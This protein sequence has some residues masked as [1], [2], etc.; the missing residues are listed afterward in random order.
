MPDEHGPDVPIGEID[1]SGAVPDGFDLTAFPDAP[2]APAGPGGGGD[3]PTFTAEASCSTQCIESGVAYPRGFGAQL[4]VETT[5]EARLWMAVV[6]DLESDGGEDGLTYANSTISN[7]RVTEFSWALDHLEPG[8]TYYVTVT[9]TDEHDNTAYAYGEFTTLSQRTVDVAI[10]PPGISGG[11]TNVVDTDVRLRVADLS[12]DLVNPP[13]TT[14]DYLSL[15]R[16]LDLAVLVFRTWATSQYTFCEGP[17]PE[18]NPPQGDSDDQCG[19]WN[20]AF[21]EVDLD[22]IPQGQSRWTEVSIQRTL[23]TTGNCAGDPRCF[24]FAVVVNLTVEYS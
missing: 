16:H 19:S 22:R 3:G 14:G 5:V 18:S 8:Q 23:Q 21:D 15:P 24:D 10:G 2:A 9:A 20:T 7:G 6:E 12:Y 17:W 13:E 1:T 11:P 4:V